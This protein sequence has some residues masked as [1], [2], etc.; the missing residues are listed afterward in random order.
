MSAHTKLKLMNDHFAK[1]DAAAKAFDENA[2]SSCDNDTLHKHLIALANELVPNSSVQ[3]RNI[4]RGITINHILLQKHIDALNKQNSKTQWLVVA[5]TI[6][7]LIGTGV[8]VWYADKADKKFEEKSSPIA[9]QQ[10][11]KVPVAEP[12]SQAPP[13][14]TTSRPP[15]VKKP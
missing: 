3:H 9:A 4:I 11:Q 8:Q 2:L 14:E 12:P 1:T 13:R 15:I 10:Q 6:A 5:L 7:S